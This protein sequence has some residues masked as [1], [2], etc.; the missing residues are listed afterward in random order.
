[1][2]GTE[3]CGGG[4]VHVAA[5]GVHGVGKRQKEKREEVWEGC[6]GRT[7]E[8]ILLLSIESRMVKGSKRSREGVG[9]READGRVLLSARG[10]QDGKRSK[11]VWEG[12]RRVAGRG[13]ETA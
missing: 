11:K 1:M 5:R 13:R 4:R 3:G 6:R 9:G 7:G 12:A 8:R 2:T 10:V